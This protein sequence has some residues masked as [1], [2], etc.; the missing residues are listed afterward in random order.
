M[1]GWWCVAGCFS[2]QR[3]DGGGGLIC[4]IFLCGG[5]LVPRQKGAVRRELSREHRGRGLSP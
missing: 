5:E 2:A 1:V 4:A 3:W